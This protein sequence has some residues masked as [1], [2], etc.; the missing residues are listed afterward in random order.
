MNHPSHVFGTR[1]GPSR[2]RVQSSKKVAKLA[3]VYGRY[4][5]LVNGGY[6]GL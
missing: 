1:W 3:M 2:V 4:H 5:E 6:N